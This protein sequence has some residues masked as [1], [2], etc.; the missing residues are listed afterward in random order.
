L[1][2]H[3]NWYG[4]QQLLTNGCEFLADPL[5]KPDRLCQVELALKFGN[6]KG[7]C[8]APDKLQS[9]LH[10]DVLHGFN[11]PVNLAIAKKIPG[12]VLSPMNI[13]LQNTIDE[14]G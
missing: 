14:T 13:A 6:H 11:L 3:P 7:A 5:A 1:S 12:L 10:N 8:K 2:H 4:I 9:L